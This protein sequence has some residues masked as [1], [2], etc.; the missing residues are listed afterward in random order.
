[1]GIGELKVRGNPAMDQQTIQGE[2]EL[3]LLFFLLKQYLLQ[4]L[5]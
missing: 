5:L 4:H 2:V 1:M 3:S